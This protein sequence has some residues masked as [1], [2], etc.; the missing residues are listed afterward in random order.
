MQRPAIAPQ[1]VYFYH[2]RQENDFVLF[3]NRG[4]L[5]DNSGAFSPNQVRASHRCNLGVPDEPTGPT[6]EYLKYS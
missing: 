4:A 2:D 5:H 3:H 1:L 6:A